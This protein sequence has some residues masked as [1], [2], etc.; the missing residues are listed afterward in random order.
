MPR[1]HK[2]PRRYEEGVAEPYYPEEPKLHY[3]QLYFQSIDA[4]I[5]TIEDR[6][7]QADYNMYAKLEP[8]LL[9]AA[10]KD[11]YSS[12]LQSVLEFYGDDFNRHELETQLQI[13]KEMEIACAGNSL[14]IRDIHSHIKS[15][16]SPQQALIS[17]VV[18]L[19]KFVLLIP[20][21]NAVPVS[22]RSAS[23]MC[24][25]KTYL[26]TSITQAR[27]NHAMVIHIHNHLTDNVEHVRVLNKFVSASDER[28]GQF[29]SF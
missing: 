2:R 7:K 21:T 16:S 13:F 17:Q 8:V 4:A 15:L 26:R 18:R 12:E 10:K 29:G 9:V 25:I 14:T 22:D 20:A 27:L 1:H 11:D 5:A 24:R 6:F 3:R 28:K 19:L 23:A